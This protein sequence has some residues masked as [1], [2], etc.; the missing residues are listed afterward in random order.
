[1]NIILTIYEHMAMIL[2]A[3][4]LDALGEDKEQTT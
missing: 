2:S 3:L 1:M 4:N